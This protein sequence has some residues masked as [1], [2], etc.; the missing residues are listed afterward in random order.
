MAAEERVERPIKKSKYQIVFGSREAKRGWRDLVA[1]RRA[2]MADAWDFLVRTPLAQTPQNYPLKDELGLVTRNGQS[3]TRWQHKP[4]LSGDAR[5][6][7][8]VVDQKVYLERVHT[9]HPNETK[10]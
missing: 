1:T 5:I 8:Y 6:W 3:F 7:F 4:A 9:H 10:R 2:N